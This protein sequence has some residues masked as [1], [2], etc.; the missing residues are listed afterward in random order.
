MKRRSNDV[1]NPREKKVL[2]RFRSPEEIQAFLDSIPYNDECS[3]RSPRRVLRD[4]KAHCFEGALVAAAALERL[5]HPPTLLDMGAVRDDDHVLAIFRVGGG[6]GALGKSNFSGLRFR[7]PVYRSLRELAMSYFD[8]YFNS[9]GE[10]TLRTYSVPY[11]LTDRAHPGWRTAEE[12][13]HDLGY[14]LN[15]LRHYP[16][17]TKTM[18]RALPP[19]DQRLLDSGLLGANPKGLY[20]PS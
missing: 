16:L 1:W 3:S 4:G 19:V 12:D 13:L 9:A 18:E 17:L 8:D 2:D 10:R 7:P 11:R 6:I 20:K 5:G 14:R 15:D